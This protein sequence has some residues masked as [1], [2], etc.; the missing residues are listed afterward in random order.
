MGDITEAYKLATRNWKVARD[1]L[2]RW[3][4]SYAYFNTMAFGLGKF[5]T[6]MEEM[7]GHWY[8]EVPTKARQKE[9]VGELENVKLVLNPVMSTPRNLILAAAFNEAPIAAAF[10]G[11]PEDRKKYWPSVARDPEGNLRD[12]FH[13]LEAKDLK[14]EQRWVERWYKEARNVCVEDPISRV[15]SDVCAGFYATL[16]SLDRRCDEKMAKKLRK[17]AK[18]IFEAE[19]IDNPVMRYTKSGF[20]GIYKLVA[21]EANPEEALK[22]LR[23]ATRYSQMS[24]NRFA[25]A[26]CLFVCCRAVAAQR[27]GPYRE[28]EADRY[29]QEAEKVAEKIGAN[30]YFDLLAAARSEVMRLRGNE[31]ETQRLDARLR[32]GQAGERILRVFQKDFRKHDR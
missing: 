3:R 23:E 15:F 8:A 18:K 20:H 27:T 7:A 30:F 21:G 6:A 10:D 32:T 29:L 11:S 22:L 2:S 25:V 14:S 19:T 5:E 16:L 12:Q 1:D 28:L 26:D 31:G 13:D 9:K 24:G 17:R 4:A